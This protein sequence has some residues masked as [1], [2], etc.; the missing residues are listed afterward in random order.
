MTPSAKYGPI[1]I[2]IYIYR[3]NCYYWRCMQRDVNKK[4]TKFSC[5]A[6]KFLITYVWLSFS[7]GTTFLIFHWQALSQTAALS[8][9]KTRSP[10][11]L[12]GQPNSSLFMCGFPSLVEQPLQFSSVRLSH[13]LQLS[14][15]HCKTRHPLFLLCNQILHYFCVAFLLQ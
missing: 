8:H 11:F 7:S 15:S 4:H 1:S 5:W 9:C 12:V 3:Q 13:K 6:T 2:I 10:N 14:L